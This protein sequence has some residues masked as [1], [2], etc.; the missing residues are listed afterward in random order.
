MILRNE[1]AIGVLPR[2]NPL[3]ARTAERDHVLHVEAQRRVSRPRTN[4]VRMET[5]RSAF[6]RPAASASVTIASVR[7][8]EELSALARGVRPLPLGRTSVAVAR[9][10]SADPSVHPVLGASQIRFRYGCRRTDS[11]FCLL[12]VF[13]SC[14]GIYATGL[15]VAVRA[16]K[17]LA[18]RSSRDTEITKFHVDVLRIT[19]D[20]FCDVVRRHAFINVLRAQPFWI[21]MQTHRDIVTTHKRGIK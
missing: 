21:E 2:V 9:V 4:V 20:D 1:L 18:T 17:V 19:I 16:A 14:E 12:G 3:V 15:H 8:A 10:E 11:T 6:P 7:I 5:S 13:P